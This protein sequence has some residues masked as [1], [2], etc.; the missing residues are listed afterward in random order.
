M[1]G[2]F[3]KSA[4]AKIAAFIGLSSFAMAAPIV[5]VPDQAIQDLKDTA[6]GIGTSAAGV[7]VAIAVV[8]LGIVVLKK[9]FR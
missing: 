4:K 5:S 9:V 8:V 2:R 7:W 1:F 3:L 6:T